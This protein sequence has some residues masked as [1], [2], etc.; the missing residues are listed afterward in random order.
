MKVHF[1]AGRAEIAQLVKK[2]KVLAREW[3]EGRKEV[4][5]CFLHRAFFFL[6][7]CP[8]DTRVI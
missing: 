6:D 7:L 2:S 4:A 1:L 3:V 8:V 5:P